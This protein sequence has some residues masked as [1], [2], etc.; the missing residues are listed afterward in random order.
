M[1]TESD[2][3]E[4]GHARKVLKVMRTRSS[5]VP[6]KYANAFEWAREWSQAHGMTLPPDTDEFRSLRNWFCYKLNQFKNDKL[7]PKNEALLAHYGLDFSQYEALNTGKGERPSDRLFAQELA[8]RK[9]D[10]GWRS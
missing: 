3:W 8:Q 4:L 9:Q 5:G 10:L 7:G 6:L 2:V 1:P